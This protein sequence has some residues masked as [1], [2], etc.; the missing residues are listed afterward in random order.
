MDLNGFGSRAMHGL[1]MTAFVIT[2]SCSGNPT[3]P[4]ASSPAQSPVTP[5]MIRTAPAITSLSISPRVEA[6][7]DVSL[8]ATVEDADTPLDLLQYEWSVAP[9]EGTFIGKGREV[10]WRAPRGAHTPD[11]YVFTLTVTDKYMAGTQSTEQRTSAS[12]AVH[13]NDS[14]EETAALGLAFLR[15]YAN[16]SVPAD[17]VVRNFS[18]SCPGKATELQE[19]QINRR[20][21]QMLGGDFSV[22]LTGLYE[23]RTVGEIVA[24]CT[25]RSVSKATGKTETAAGTCSLTTVYENWRWMLC[26]SRFSVRTAA[27]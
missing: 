16:T 8:T 17:Q 6:D 25:F 21:Y 19:V 27:Q 7:D 22:A 2:A 9:S 14:H 4:T 26:D 13:Y 24:P 18:D 11:V 20:D 12:L 1:A 5:P 3:Q 23:N 15:D 10:T